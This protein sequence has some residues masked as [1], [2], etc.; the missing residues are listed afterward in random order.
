MEGLLTRLAHLFCYFGNM[1]TGEILRGICTVC[2][3]KY[4]GTLKI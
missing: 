3:E 2:F 4:F 1:L